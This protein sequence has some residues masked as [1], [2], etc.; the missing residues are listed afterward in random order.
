MRRT[1]PTWVLFAVL[2]LILL[3][4]V[5]LADPT[6]RAAIPFLR[7]E[8]ALGVAGT[9][10]AVHVEGPGS[11]ATCAESEGQMGP[12]GGT[13]YR[14]EPGELPGPR[15]LICRQPAWTPGVTVTVYDAG[16]LMQY[17]H[18]MCGTL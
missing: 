8:C 11:D 18:E 10:L 2:V 15:V 16:S 7:E 3:G 12:G 5:A 6:A 9:A 17:G 13:W 14:I 1:I 4:V